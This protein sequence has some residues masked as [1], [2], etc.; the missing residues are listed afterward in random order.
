MKKFTILTDEVKLSIALGVVSNQ[1]NDYAELE[2][3]ASERL[4]LVKTRFNSYDNW[5]R[6]GGTLIDG[7][8]NRENTSEYKYIVFES[9]SR[10]ESFVVVFNKRLIHRDVS[11]ALAK[12][13]RK[14]SFG[15]KPKRAGFCNVKSKAAFGE[16]DSLSLSSDSQKDSFLIK[17]LFKG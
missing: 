5:S 14:A 7:E 4:N 8:F 11:E 2:Q 12:I 9:P 6:L 10:N 16:S 1:D 13:T 3:L 15:I 17:E